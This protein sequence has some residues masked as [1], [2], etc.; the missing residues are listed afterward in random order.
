MCIKAETK[1]LPFCLWFSN[2]F[3]CMPIVF[4]F[5]FPNLISY[6]SNWEWVGWC[7]DNGSVLERRWAIMWTNNGLVRWC[8]SMVSWQ[9]SLPAMLT[10]GRQGPFGR[11]PSIYAAVC[12]DALINIDFNIDNFFGNPG[13]K[14]CQIWANAGNINSSPPGAAYMCQWI[15]SALL[16]IMACR[17]C[18]AK[19]LPKSALVNWT[20]RNKPQWNFNQNTK[21]FIHKNAFENIACEMAA[22][23]SRGRWVNSNPAQHWSFIAC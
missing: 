18:G 23:L 11:I 10:H 19:P 1:Q 12:I 6:G 20:H 5:K 9:R 16:Q 17:L 14:L 13:S 7:L 15:G 3:S 21:L 4:L 2:S 8:I 22:I